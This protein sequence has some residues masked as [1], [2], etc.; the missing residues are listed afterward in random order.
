MNYSMFKHIKN[1]NFLEKLRYAITII[2]SGFLNLY[3]SKKLEKKNIWLIGAGDDIF[4]NNLKVFY[5]FLKNKKDI[6]IYWIANK[7]NIKRLSKYIDRN[8]L[9]ERGSIKNY[10]YARNSKV[11]IYGFSDKD[12]APGIFRLIKRKSL[13]VNISHGFEGLKGMPKNYYKPLPVDILCAASTFEKEVKI[14]YC[15]ADKEKV[16]VTG[17][18][19]Y[20]EWNSN[21][22]PERIKNILIMPTWRDWYITENIRWND[23][24]MFKEY[25]NLLNEMDKLAIRKKINIKCILHPALDKF[26]GKTNLFNLKNIKIITSMESI[27]E[28]LKE[29]DLLIT[30]YSS[31]YWDFVYMKKNVI[32]YW[33]DYDEYKSKRGLIADKT[34]T[35]NIVYKFDEMIKIINEKIENIYTENNDANRYFDW[36][37]NENCQRIYEIILNKIQ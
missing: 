36:F 19:R 5:N 29:S 10:I 14:N 27:Q 13:L 18:P 22:R 17:F 30:D 12:I 4:S 34:L 3:M 9:I 11:C 6:D 32:L 1:F 2:I 16:I 24:H 35:K 37:D 8:K 20:D 26:Y 23:T 31:I 15:G 33:F 21:S 28:L 7:G 25:S